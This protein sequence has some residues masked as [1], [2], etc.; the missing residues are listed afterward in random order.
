MRV[1]EI[2]N[3]LKIDVPQ[4][5]DKDQAS[6][7]TRIVNKVS[8]E[9]AWIDK[10]FDALSLSF[11]GDDGFQ[12]K[13]INMIDP[14]VRPSTDSDISYAEPF[15]R[16]F[17]MIIEKTEGTPEEKL[18]FAN[19][20]GK[21]DHIDVNALTTPGLN[22]WD[23]WLTGSEFGK[24]VFANLFDHPAFQSHNK[25]PGEAALALLSPKIS[26]APGKVGDLIINGIEVEVKGGVSSSGGRL[27]P[28]KNSIGNLYDDTRFWSFLFPND[29]NKAAE[30]SKKTVTPQEFEKFVIENELTSDHI[31]KIL[32]AVFK[33]ADPSVIDAAAS[34]GGKRNDIAKVAFSN[35][36]GSQEIDK[37]LIIQSNNKKT[38][39]FGVND[40]DSALDLIS[41]KGYVISKDTR[42]IGSIQIGLYKSNEKA[43]A[44][45]GIVK[46]SKKPKEPTS[47]KQ[48]SIDTQ[49]NQKAE[50]Q[51]SQKIQDPANPL[52]KAWKEIPS[53]SKAEA[54]QIII[55]EIAKGTADTEIAKLLSD[56]AFESI[57]INLKRLID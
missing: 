46:K 28:T 23:Q 2:L 45:P 54:Q 9:P 25:G 47:I 3:E 56:L 38:L 37:F 41:V 35:Y 21:V 39:F 17:A 57:L 52:Y 43:A 6:K 13:I 30:L 12:D 44:S 33:M 26:L 5:L 40:L 19:T 24:R 16:N 49:D 22:S 14:A 29:P 50:Q 51:L 31:K 32:S 11:K 1:S 55:D 8:N 4:N 7:L 48:T 20:L 36:S 42:S 10:I 53:S 15:L 18:K 34:S 27:D